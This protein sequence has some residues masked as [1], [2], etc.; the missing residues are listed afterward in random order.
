MTE[1]ILAVVE[2]K[3]REERGEEEEGRGGESWEGG[4]EARVVEAPLVHFRRLSPPCCLD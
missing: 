3:T 4:G 1:K 2:R